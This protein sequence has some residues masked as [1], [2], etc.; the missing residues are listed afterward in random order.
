VGFPSLEQ[1]E[2]IL[3]NKKGAFISVEL[4]GSDFRKN[5]K[6]SLLKKF[7]SALD[8]KNLFKRGW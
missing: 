6:V 1:G 2:V 4:N 7:K 3:S 8:F 5:E